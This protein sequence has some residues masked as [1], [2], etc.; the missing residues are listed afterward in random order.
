MKNTD[1]KEEVLNVIFDFPTKRFHIRELSRILK[2]SPPA[3]SKAVKE[4]EKDSLITTEKS[5]IHSI[6]ANLEN[7]RFKQ[8][9]RVKNLSK[10]YDSGL[11]DYLKEQFPDSTIVLFRSYADGE[12]TEKDNIA[13]A[14]LNSKE[15]KLSLAQFEQQLNRK[16]EIVFTKPNESI[17]NGIKLYGHISL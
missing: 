12:D 14:V 11:S 3:I 4:L 15:K 2:I 6:S 5:I 17:I 8:I 9:K 7:P 13:I 16:I 10:I 1:T